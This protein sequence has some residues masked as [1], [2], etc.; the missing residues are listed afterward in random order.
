[1]ALSLLL[2]LK[3][4]TQLNVLK[5]KV[6]EYTDDSKFIIYYKNSYFS[7]WKVWCEIP[8]C[9]DDR[10]NFNLAMDAYEKCILANTRKPKK[11]KT[12][13]VAKNYL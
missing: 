10:N 4:G 11:P 3:V 1:M 6:V 7:K 9:T 12:K 13:I 5:V 8:I 2:I